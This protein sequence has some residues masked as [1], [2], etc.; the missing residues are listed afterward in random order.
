MNNY[1]FIQQIGIELHIMCQLLFQGL[2]NQPG[3]DRNYI[4][5][6]FT[7]V[8]TSPFITSPLGG[9][10]NQFCVAG[11]EQ[12][13]LSHP[14]STPHLGVLGSFLSRLRPLTSSLSSLLFWLAG[15][16]PEGHMWF[17][18]HCLSIRVL[19]LTHRNSFSLSLCSR[20]VS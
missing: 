11:K 10:Y 13:A 19:N 6:G 20:H 7:T 3:E 9:R 8:F 1:P 2:G 16:L 4:T 12:R 17:P 14:L 18:T 5:L 15:V